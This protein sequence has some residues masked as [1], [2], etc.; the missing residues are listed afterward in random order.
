MILTPDTQDLRAIKAQ[1]IIDRA[2]ASEAKLPE[3]YIAPV[4]EAK[5]ELSQPKLVTVTPSLQP[6]NESKQLIDKINA[7]LG[8]SPISIDDISPQQQ[9]EVLQQ[10]K[11]YVADNDIDVTQYI[12]PEVKTLDDVVDDGSDIPV[13]KVKKK[14]YFDTLVD[15]I[16]NLVF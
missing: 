4:P 14:G 5:V 7:M 10:A 2:L 15:Y 6:A 3:P 9:A 13:A 11:Q 8:I 16:Y 1:A 12:T